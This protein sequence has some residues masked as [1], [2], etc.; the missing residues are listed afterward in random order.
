VPKAILIHNASAGIREPTLQQLT[1]LIEASGY[2]VKYRNSKRPDLEA[3]LDK[4]GDLVVA[5]GG[6]GTIAKVARSCS[7]SRIRACP[8]RFS[9]SARRTTS[10]CPSGSPNGPRL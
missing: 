7:A 1:A 2:R 4:Q 10:R 8:W 9:P 3:K 6:D 5:A